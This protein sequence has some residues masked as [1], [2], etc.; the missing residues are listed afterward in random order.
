MAGTSEKECQNC[1]QTLSFARCLTCVRCHESNITVNT[2]SCLCRRGVCLEFVSSLSRVC[3]VFVSVCLGFVS[4]L[5]RH[6]NHTPWCP[7]TRARL[8]RPNHT[9]KRLRTKVVWTHQDLCGCPHHATVPGFRG[10]R[11]RRGATQRVGT[12]QSTP[13]GPREAHAHSNSTTRLIVDGKTLHG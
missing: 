11:E 2:G 12:E 13:F 7:S 6:V 9:L 3:L 10:G 8:S 5:S 1:R 4:G